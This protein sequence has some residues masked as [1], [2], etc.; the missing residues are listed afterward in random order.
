M[1]SSALAVPAALAAA[2]CYATASALQHHEARRSSAGDTVAVA[3]MLRLVRR[4]LW[5]AGTAADIAGVLLHILALGLGPVSLVQPLQ[6][7]GLLYALPLA[8]A[9][10]RRRPTRRD[11]VAALAVVL[12]LALFLGLARPPAADTLL[13][14]WTAAL[15]VGGAL[16]VLTVGTLLVRRLPPPRRAAVMGG[17]AGC[18]F[19]VGS[20]LLEDLGQR[21]AASGWSGLLEAGG[22]IGLLGAVALGLVGLGLSQAAFQVGTLGQ[23]LPSLTVADPV[24][25]VV[26]ASLLLGETLSLRPLAVTA[27]LLAVALVAAG[28][29]RLARAEEEPAAEALPQSASRPAPGPASARL[30][31][32]DLA[33]AAG[34][35]GLY[36]MLPAV[37]AVAAMSSADTDEGPVARLL[38][39]LATVAVC[40]ATGVWQR[41]RRTAPARTG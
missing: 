38:V 35:G 7:T 30:P 6:V 39:L 25:S 4:P 18:G 16:V 8:G 17:L 40:A 2:A 32:R 19:A 22:L 26:L 21:R 20:V 14:P 28:V 33:A 27:D 1:S 29:V 12:G 41:I 9:L 3:G 31:A 36:G 15:L 24:L 10:T 34:I 11:L 23:A 37:V 13:R 5:L